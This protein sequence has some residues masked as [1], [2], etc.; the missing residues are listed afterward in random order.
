VSP[1][2]LEFVRARMEVTVKCFCVV[3][4]VFVLA[5]IGEGQWLEKEMRLPD[6]MCGLEESDQILFNAANYHAYIGGR[7]ADN[8]QIFDYRARAKAGTIR[9]VGGVAD[10]F[11]CPD[12]QRVVLLGANS[13]RLYTLDGRTDA[14]LEST[15]VA[16]SLSR[17]VYNPTEHKAYIGARG[18]SVLFV[19][20]PGPDTLLGS[21]D[22]VDA[23]T[24]LAFDSAKNRVFCM[25]YAGSDHGIEVIDC[26]GDTLV[27]VLPTSD[28]CYDLAF[29]PA[30]RRL[31]CLTFNTTTWRD[32]VW[33]YDVDSLVLLDTL[34]LPGSCSD[35][36]R[37]LLNG[38]SHRL[39]AGCT[40]PEWGGGS[41]DSIAVIDCV[42]NTIAGLVG[43]PDEA[44]VLDWGLNRTD[45]KVY[46]CTEDIDSI[47]VLGAPDSITGWVRTGAPSRCAGWNQDNGEVLI[48]GY[49]RLDVASG[50]SDSII[51]RVDYMPFLMGAMCWNPIH[52]KLYV[53]GFE[54]GMLVIDA[55]NNIIKLLRFTNPYFWSPSA[56]P[57]FSPERD[58]IFVAAEG[59]NCMDV[60][61][62]SRDS[63]LF[64]QQMPF[65]LYPA[66]YVVPEHRKLYWP[67]IADTTAV[68]DIN[69][70]SIVRIR[71]GLGIRFV[72]SQRM[73]LIYGVKDPWVRVINPGTDSALQS[74]NIPSSKGLAVSETDNELYVSAGSALVVVDCST[75]TIK[76]TIGLTQTPEAL[77]WYEPLDK[78]YA[79]GDS[80]SVV[81]CRSH[82]VLKTIPIVHSL[83]KCAVLSEGT[84]SL[85]VATNDS[86]YAINCAADSAVSVFRGFWWQVGIVANSTDHRVY[87]AGYDRLF[88]YRD[89]ITGLQAEVRQPVGFSLR[90]KS[91][92][93]ARWV[94][95]EC[96]LSDARPGRL[97]IYDASGRKVWS[98]SGTAGSRAV[99]WSG[100]DENGRR[101]APGVY[102]ARLETGRARA[103]T[104]VVLTE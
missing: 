88:I 26:A 67:S 86:L 45:D 100:T 31:Y 91:N 27:D 80:V 66:M 47:A 98:S 10:M 59:W 97:S 101:L 64:T 60:F 20:D 43:L 23:V 96:T 12:R 70:D 77:Y 57:P 18:E 62:C 46:I 41:E 30:A 49:E 32:Q 72:A 54:T 8:V 52:D 34:L 24:R 58:R 79:L 74:I 36:G 50:A 71:A 56:Y 44:E 16:E 14:L 1:E 104:K 103:T 63:L 35:A 42:T 78:L 51:L 99:S 61:D 68:Y 3:A 81:S 39:Y 87:Q 19:F 93:S 55:Q 83:W 89:E 76:D 37:L 28:R 84:G 25:A 33:V 5:G 40:Y 9:D 73:G 7:D 6:S 38:A 15:Y 85:W 11:L 22:L 75:N 13:G 29:D 53:F 48:P 17:G 90:P 94:R 4:L 21:I 69:T 82:S 102:L 95:F 2:F 65:H 92:P